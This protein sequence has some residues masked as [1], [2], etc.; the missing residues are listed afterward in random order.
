MTIWDVM[1]TVQER[2]QVG[3]VLEVRI[4]Q[5][6]FALKS[7]MTVWS[8]EEKLVMME[9]QT[10]GDVKLSVLAL[11]KVGN[12][13]TEMKNLLQFAHQSVGMESLWVK[14]LVMT[15]NLEIEKDVLMIV[16]MR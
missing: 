14:S 3:T 6:P 1:S 12:V 15:E 7:V 10:L 13:K 2:F 8:L 9:K 5:K 11:E 16:K 4:Q